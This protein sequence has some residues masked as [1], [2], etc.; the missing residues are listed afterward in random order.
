MRA[1]LKGCP[2]WLYICSHLGF[3]S[4][5][6]LGRYASFMGLLQVQ[7]LRASVARALGPVARRLE[8]SWALFIRRVSLVMGPLGR[9][10][11]SS[12]RARRGFGAGLRQG[13]EGLDDGSR[14][15]GGE[16]LKQRK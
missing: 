13:A 14:R 6:R 9:I 12:P 2:W 10:P 8:L 11:I 16:L 3:T 4:A 5:G 1:G 7:S 15:I